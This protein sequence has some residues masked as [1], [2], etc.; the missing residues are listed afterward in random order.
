MGNRKCG[1]GTVVF[2]EANTQ[3]GFEVWDAGVRFLNIRQGLAKFAE[4]GGA[5]VNPYRTDPES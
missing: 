1:P 5:G 3:Y 2:I 4:A